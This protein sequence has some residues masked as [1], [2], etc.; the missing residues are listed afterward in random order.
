MV[1]SVT[2]GDNFSRSTPRALFVS[3][4]LPDAD[5]YSYAV[6]PDGQRILFPAANPDAP[7]REIHVVLNFFEELRERLGN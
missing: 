4:N 6:S 3:S 5:S 2:T 1:S 7:A